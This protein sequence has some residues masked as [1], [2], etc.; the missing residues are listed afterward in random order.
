MSINEDSLLDHYDDSECLLAA[1][2]N[3]MELSLALIICN[4]CESTMATKILQINQY[5]HLYI[6]E[7]C[8]DG[9]KSYKARFCGECYYPNVQQYDKTKSIVM[10]D[11]LNDNHNLVNIFDTVNKPL[12]DL[13][14]CEISC[15]I[16][17]KYK[18][19]SMLQSQTNFFKIDF[20]IG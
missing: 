3:E 16:C 4:S 20:Y 17:T 14:K 12:L 13:R 11:E 5:I 1:I 19:R 9:V 6:C 18:Y 7:K 10:H 15:D 2:N 8:A